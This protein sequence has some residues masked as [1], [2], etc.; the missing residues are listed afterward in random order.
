M[1]ESE[2][3]QSIHHWNDYSQCQNRQSLV[4]KGH[5]FQK[6]ILAVKFLYQ[7]DILSRDDCLYKKNKS[8]VWVS[9][10]ARKSKTVGNASQFNQTGIVSLCLQ[11]HSINMVTLTGVK[12]DSATNRARAFNCSQLA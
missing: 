7:E 1:E 4:R 5:I 11:P 6:K 12:K 8:W 9:G 10:T 3:H 2:P